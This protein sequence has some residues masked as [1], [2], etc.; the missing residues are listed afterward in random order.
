MYIDFHTHHVAADGEAVIQD[1][2]HTWGIHPWHISADTQFSAP[3]DLTHILAIGECGLDRLAGAPMEQQESLFREHIRLSEECRKPLF[4][5]CVRTLDDVLRLRRQMRATQPWIIHGFRGKPRQLQ[6][7]LSAGMYVS[8]GFHYR[9]ESVLSC[10]PDRMLLETDDD[11]R[12]PISAL[13][14]EVAA[15]LHTDVSSLCKQMQTNYRMLFSQKT[16]DS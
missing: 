5:H 4:I 3:A 2:V 8:F 15:L 14:A 6:S 12:R 13:Y 7:I 1:G 10:P 9:A 11:T 16:S